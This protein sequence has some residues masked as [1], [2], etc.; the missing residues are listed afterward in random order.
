MCEWGDTVMVN[1]VMP[2][3][4][5]YTGEQR[6][7]PKLIDRCIAPIVAALVEAGILT[8][9]SCCGHGKADGEIQLE[10]GRTLMIKKAEYD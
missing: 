9:S 5:S 4:L 8:R 10:D 6:K 1:V 3:D 2:V 7:C